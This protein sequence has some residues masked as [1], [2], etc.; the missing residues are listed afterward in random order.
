MLQAAGVGSVLPRA[1]VDVALW[2]LVG[3]FA[4]GILM[5]AASRSRPERLVMTPVALLLAAG[6]LALALA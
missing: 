6:C 2:V 4:L 3:Y 1:F 5:N